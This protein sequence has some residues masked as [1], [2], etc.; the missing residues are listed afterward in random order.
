[1]ANLHDDGFDLYHFNQN[2]YNLGR[3]QVFTEML[4]KIL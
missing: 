1:M 4:L 3:I 2:E